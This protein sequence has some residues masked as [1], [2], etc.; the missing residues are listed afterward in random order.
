MMMQ[1]QIFIPVVFAR[2]CEV[3]MIFTLSLLYFWYLRKSTNLTYIYTDLLYLQSIKFAYS[4]KCRQIRC[5]SICLHHCFANVVEAS[6]KNICACFT[7]V[8]LQEQICSYTLNLYYNQTNKFAL[9]ISHL[10]SMQIWSS[11]MNL[12]PLFSYL[13]IHFWNYLITISIQN[14]NKSY[15]IDY[16]LWFVHKTPTGIKRKTDFSLTEKRF[17]LTPRDEYCGRES[18]KI[19]M[20][21]M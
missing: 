14:I 4:T 6:N 13:Y 7:H 15:I 5:K 10:P 12:Q 8:L 9:V 17:S 3:N 2:K 18:T 20:L 16:K 21:Y 1:I 19:K 11:S